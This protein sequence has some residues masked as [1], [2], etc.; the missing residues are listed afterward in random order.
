MIDR[1]LI[2]LIQSLREEPI[3]INN[4]RIFRNCEIGDARVYGVDV[5]G[6]DTGTL[7][8]INMDGDKA[9][10]EDPN[11]FK[12]IFCINNNEFNWYSK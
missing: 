10:Q 11:F 1:Y 2:K 8:W 12:K 4:N 6:E 5:T 7:H 9:V 3:V